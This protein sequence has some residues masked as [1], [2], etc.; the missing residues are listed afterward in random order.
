MSTEKSR[1]RDGA[2][3]LGAIMTSSVKSRPLR[4]SCW[5]VPRPFFRDDA[6]FASTH[7]SRA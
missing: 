4:A 2:S 1:G 7:S 6:R 5:R 3:G